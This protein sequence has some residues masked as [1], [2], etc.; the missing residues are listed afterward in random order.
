MLLGNLFMALVLDLYTFTRFER[1]QQKQGTTKQNPM[2]I[3]LYTYWHKLKGEA[4]VGVEAEDAVG[5]ADE[6]YICADQLPGVVVQ[7]IEEQKARCEEMLENPDVPKEML[8]EHH[9]K[10]STASSINRP[11]A[12][13]Y[14]SQI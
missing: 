3:F 6:Q 5:S 14:F 9:Y 8:D 1:R 7:A 12:H 2:A 10:G 13:N 4:L 11:K